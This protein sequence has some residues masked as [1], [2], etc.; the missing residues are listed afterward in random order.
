MA[1]PRQ[2]GLSA[3]DIAGLLSECETLRDRLID[4]QDVQETQRRTIAD[5][6]AQLRAAQRVIPTV[7]LDEPGPI[8]Q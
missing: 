4:A 7:A 5:L 8:P 3:D 2:R 1:A 6:R